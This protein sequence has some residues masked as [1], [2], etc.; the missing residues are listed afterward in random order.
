MLLAYSEGNYVGKDMNL[1]SIG[2]LNGLKNIPI[3][4][5]CCVLL[6]CEMHTVILITVY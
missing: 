5:S 3:N 1:V 2:K 4:I 6:V